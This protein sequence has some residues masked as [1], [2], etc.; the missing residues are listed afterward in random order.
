MKQ[1]LFYPLL[2]TFLIALFAQPSPKSVLSRY[3]S[4]Y[5]GFFSSFRY[6]LSGDPFGDFGKTSVMAFYNGNFT[7]KSPFPRI[8]MALVITR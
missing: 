4:T 1:L 6:L 8:S 5:F 7:E 3:A 2:A